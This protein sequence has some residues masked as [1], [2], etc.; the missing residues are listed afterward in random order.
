MVRVV[1]EDALAQFAI[2]CAAICNRSLLT[3]HPHEFQVGSWLKTGFTTMLASQANYR[4]ITNVG[5]IQELRL[6]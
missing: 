1:C 3:P 6:G 2:R 4:L 5:E